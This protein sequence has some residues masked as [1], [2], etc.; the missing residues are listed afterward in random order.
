MVMQC[1]IRN[2]KQILKSLCILISLNSSLR[3]NHDALDEHLKQNRDNGILSS[4]SHR[5][6]IKQYYISLLY[7]F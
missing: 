3:K 7:L 2:P 1:S 4:E 5:S 6:Q